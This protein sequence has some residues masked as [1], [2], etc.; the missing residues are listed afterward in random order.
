MNTEETC[1]GR[2]KTLTAYLAPI[3]YPKSRVRVQHGHLRQ[4]RSTLDMHAFRGRTR[5]L[6]RAETYCDLSTLL[7]PTLVDI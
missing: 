3:R 6:V 2:W 5:R 1:V 7:E 4:T